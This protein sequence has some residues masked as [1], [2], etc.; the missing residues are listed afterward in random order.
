MDQYGGSGFRFEPLWRCSAV[1][2]G[3][4]L[5]PSEFLIPQN[6]GRPRPPRSTVC[7]RA[8]QFR[9]TQTFW[10]GEKRRKMTKLVRGKQM[11]QDKVSLNAAI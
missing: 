10:V 9:F 3:Y 7:I 1:D 4:L 11:S 5:N 6:L 2:Y 8:I